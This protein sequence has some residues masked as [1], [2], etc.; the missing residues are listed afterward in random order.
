MLQDT[1][2]AA[3]PFTLPPLLVEWWRLL[4][5]HPPAVHQARCFDRLRALVDGGVRCAAPRAAP[6]RRCS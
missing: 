6:S 5:A 2:P 1:M 4:A 3:A